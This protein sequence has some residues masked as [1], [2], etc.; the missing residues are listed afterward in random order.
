METAKKRV[1]HW[2]GGALFLGATQAG[3]SAP[4][5]APPT[6]QVALT[7]AVV[8]CD[9]LPL[10]GMATRVFRSTSS[11][12]FYALPEQWHVVAAGTHEMFLHENAATASSQAAA[13]TSPFF[14]ETFVRYR[15]E[16]TTFEPKD[17]LVAALRDLT[18]L[19]TIDL[20]ELKSVS[21]PSVKATLAVEPTDLVWLKNEF[22]GTDVETTVLV[23]NQTTSSGNETNKFVNAFLGKAGIVGLSRRFEYRCAADASAPA[24]LRSVEFR[25]GVAPSAGAFNEIRYDVAGLDFSNDTEVPLGAVRLLDY[26]EYLGSD[27]AN[28]P[29]GQAE[30]KTVQ[31][32]YL[33]A[34]WASWRDRA[35][36]QFRSNATWGEPWGQGAVSLR[37][38]RSNADA[39]RA[40]LLR[41]VQ[42]GADAL[43][44]T[45]APREFLARPNQGYVDVYVASVMDELDRAVAFQSEHHLQSFSR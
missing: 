38:I 30:W 29:A 4:S 9:P 16:W 5:E 28:A 44:S 33:Q 17:D 14:K 20:R 21:P 40:D 27:F 43:G 39:L 41:I 36:A 1:I 37:D 24:E 7:D 8:S 11:S 42:A 3:C 2:V 34:G 12:V 35:A 25:D 18:G 32:A 10:P 31:D 22:P 15:V 13:G 45:L 19:D 23:R 26:L 6:A